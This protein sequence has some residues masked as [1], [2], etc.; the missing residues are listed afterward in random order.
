VNIASCGS[1]TGHL[2]VLVRLDSRRAREWSAEEVARRW[3]SL[4]PLRNT[5]GNALPG[6]QARVGLLAQDAGWVAKVR[7]RLGDLSWFMKCSKRI[8][9]RP[10][11]A[12]ASSP[13]SAILDPHGT[14]RHFSRRELSRESLRWSVW[15][16]V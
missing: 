4:F 5:A 16:Q 14:T 8:T 2:H 11:S 6:S 3:L 13:S 12:L 10:R 9:R 7:K 15:F 1:R